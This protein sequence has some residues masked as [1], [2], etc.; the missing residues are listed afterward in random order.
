MKDSLLFTINF[1]QHRLLPPN[2]I[3]AM[4]IQRKSLG[5]FVEEGILFIRGVNQVLLRCIAGGEVTNVLQEVY[6]G[7]CGEGQGSS[8]LSKKIMHID[9]YLPTMEANS[10]FFS[11]KMSDMLAPW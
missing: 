5:F 3:N 11:S 1:L 10:L 6:A 2:C 9:Y 7:E 8:R 4:K